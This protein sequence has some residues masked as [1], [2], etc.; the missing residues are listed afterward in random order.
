MAIND[1]GNQRCLESNREA[2]RRCHIASCHWD[3]SAYG[4]L[5]VN[6]GFVTD[7]MRNSGAHMKPMAPPPSFSRIRLTCHWSTRGRPTSSSQFEPGG[8]PKSKN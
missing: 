8:T 3:G 1:I 7:V 6:V 2:M 5:S 4:G